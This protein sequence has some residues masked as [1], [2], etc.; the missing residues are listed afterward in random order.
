MPLR[1]THKFPKQIEESAINLL[2]VTQRF[3]FL[4]LKYWVDAK[5]YFCI[6]Q[7]R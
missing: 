7:E 4:S 5:G 1:A 3:C 6:A 2:F